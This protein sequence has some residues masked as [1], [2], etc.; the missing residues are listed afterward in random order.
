MQPDFKGLASSSFILELFGAT[1]NR[2]L[3]APR[4][5]GVSPCRNSSIKP[6]GMRLDERAALPKLK[7]SLPDCCFRAETSAWAL[8]FTRRGLLHCAWWSVVEKSTLG[9]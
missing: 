5:T 8:D 4:T 2:G 3:P 1:L 6:C 9:R 7:R